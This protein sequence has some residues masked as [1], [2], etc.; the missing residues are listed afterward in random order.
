[1]GLPFLTGFYSKDLIIELI[2]GENFLRFALWLGVISAFITAFYSFRLLNSTFFNNIQSNFKFFSQSHEGKWNLRLPLIILIIFSIISGYIFQ[3]FI[4]KDEFPIIVTNLSKFSPLIVSLLGS[5]LALLLGF[6]IMRWWKIW[7]NSIN[8]KLYSF[9]NSAWYFDNIFNY[10]ISKPIMNFGLFISY[11]L[12]D[13]QVLE[14]FGPSN[15]YT[16]ISN[17]T[18]K[19]STIYIGKLSIYILI[20]IVFIFFTLLKF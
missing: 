18:S 8:I 15:I 4:L 19:I 7:M 14:F 17:T 3:F 20:F 6:F 1:M 10:Y 9:T 5:F 11:K 2:Y 12:I 16:T 13:N